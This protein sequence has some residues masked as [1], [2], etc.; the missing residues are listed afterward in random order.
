MSQHQP[1]FT[2]TVSNVLFGKSLQRLRSQPK[3][4]RESTRGRLTARE[5]EL[6]QLV[7]EG[8]SNTEVGKALGVSIRTTEK[9]RATVMDKLGLQSVAAL[10]RY[11]IRNK[12]IDA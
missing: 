6:V 9:C 1:F 4:S 7:A 12:I 2:D 11:A 8:K 5:R 10:T 3:R